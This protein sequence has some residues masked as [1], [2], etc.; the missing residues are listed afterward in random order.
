[1][2]L[3]LIYR[4][5]ERI[6]QT[7]AIPPLNREQLNE[8]CNEYELSKEAFSLKRSGKIVRTVRSSSTE[9]RT[10]VPLTS[11]TS[12]EHENILP[13][14]SLKNPLLLAEVCILNYYN[15]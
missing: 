5:K 2:R 14:E 9:T 15:L 1:M 3:I 4:Y 13:V 10:W 11:S 8:N 6:T 7:P 12:V